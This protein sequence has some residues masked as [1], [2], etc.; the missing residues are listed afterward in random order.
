[1]LG[2]VPFQ[3]VAEAGAQ[4]QSSECAPKGQNRPQL[5]S[6]FSLVTLLFGLLQLL[7]DIFT[8]LLFEE[9]GP[10]IGG[11][12][13]TGAVAEGKGTEY[14]VDQQEQENRSRSI[15]SGHVTSLS[16]G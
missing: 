13:C 12:R 3:F 10:I 16:G 14:A 7:G 1:M 2:T 4:D 6:A 11:G 5:N 15:G 8:P 9:L